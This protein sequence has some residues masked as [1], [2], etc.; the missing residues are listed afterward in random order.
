V[1][2]AEDSKLMDAVQ[3]HNDKD[4]VA[5]SALVPGRTKIQCRGR[6]HYSLEPSMGRA[7]AR[8]SK[9]A[10]VEVTKLTDAVLTHGDKNWKVPRRSRG[11]AKKQCC[12][13]WKKDM[14]H[15][16]CIAQFGEHNTSL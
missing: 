13:T 9:S 5:I 4:W 10:K 3:T 15:D 11:E 2:E 12:D 6:W 8:K 7:S 1:H 16:R 14:D